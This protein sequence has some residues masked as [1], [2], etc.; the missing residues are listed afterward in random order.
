MTT[1]FDTPPKA[2]VSVSTELVEHQVPAAEI[3]PMLL[4]ER[5]MASGHDPGK[6]YEL[7][8]QWRRDMAAE[9][10][11]TQLA[12]FQ[13]A[14]PQ[15]RKTRQIDLGGG[16]GPL[17]A[18]LD[19]I[20]HQIKPLLSEHGLAV[21]YSAGITDGGQLTAKCR[22]HHGTHVEESEITLPVPAQMR[23]NDTQKMGAALSYAKRYALCAALNIIVSDE[24]R[25]GEGLLE[26]VSEE[27]IA[28]L[29]EWIANTESN[30]SAFLKFMGVK[31]LS[32]IPVADFGKAV[33]ALKRKAKR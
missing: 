14:C 25:D 30:E 28:T 12:K 9:Q 13:A 32:E 21:T 8:Q 17:Y 1:L 3:T 15:I 29:R 20:M 26:T 10:F 7:A 5:A 18:S 16:K 23:V 27:H 31:A 19:D 6:L 11:A 22:I 24:D 4:I 33:D 2:E